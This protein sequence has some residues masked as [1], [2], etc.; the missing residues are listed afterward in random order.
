MPKTYYCFSCKQVYPRARIAKS[1]VRSNGSK[2]FVCR[3]CHSSWR[4]AKQM[5]QEAY[6][7]GQSDRVMTDEGFVSMGWNGVPSERSLRR[8]KR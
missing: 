8:R 5:D 7:K 1:G 6:E 2:W 3:E 4:T